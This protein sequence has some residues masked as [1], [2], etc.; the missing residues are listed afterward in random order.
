MTARIHGRKIWSHAFWEGISS[1]PIPHGKHFPISQT[2]KDVELY[3]I[4]LPMTAM[5][6]TA[7]RLNKRSAETHTFLEVRDEE[8]L[9][10]K[11]RLAGWCPI[12]TKTVAKYVSQ[13]LILGYFLQWNNGVNYIMSSLRFHRYSSFMHL[14]SNWRK[15]KQ[16]YLGSQPCISE[17]S[18]VTNGPSKWRCSHDSLNFANIPK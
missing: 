18:T 6:V 17:V 16:L 13:F 8:S 9:H 5:A 15:N 10:G 7:G 3:I 11:A 1:I 4:R 2:V 14:L 12:V